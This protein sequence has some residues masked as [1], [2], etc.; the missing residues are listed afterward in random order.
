VVITYTPKDE[1]MEIIRQDIIIQ[2]NPELGDQVETIYIERI[3]SNDDST[4]QK[5]MTWEVEKGFQILSIIQNKDGAET[6]KNKAV[7]WTNSRS[8]E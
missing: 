3:L 7:S 8:A 4:V 6:I 2:P 1:D 5:K